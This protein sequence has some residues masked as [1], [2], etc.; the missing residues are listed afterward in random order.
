MSKSFKKTIIKAAVFIIA[1]AFLVLIDQWT[2]KLAVDGLKNSLPVIIW[3]NV[4]ELRYLENTGAA[5]GLM[6]GMRKLFLLIT[7][8]IC[9]FLFIISIKLYDRKRMRA[10][11]YCFLFITAGA[12]GNFIDRLLYAYVVDFIYV[13]LIDFPIF[14]VAD[15]YVTCGSIVLLLLLIFKYKEEDFDRRTDL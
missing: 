15:I 7:P 11:C 9:L 2:K 12:I 10:L 6:K 8:F 4:L 5:F 1:V 14:N 3:N 13:S